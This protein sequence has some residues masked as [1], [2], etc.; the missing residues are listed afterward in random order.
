LRNDLPDTDEYI[1]ELRKEERK[2]VRELKRSLSPKPEPKLKVSSKKP[3][4][5]KAELAVPPSKSKFIYRWG[6]PILIAVY[7]CYLIVSFA[8]FSP[9]GL[10]VIVYLFYIAFLGGIWVVMITVFIMGRIWDLS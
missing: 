4:R 7:L 9:N 6:D 3:R 1:I 2:K 8:W 5:L 10:E